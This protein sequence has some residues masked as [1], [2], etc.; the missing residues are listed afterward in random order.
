[1][2]VQRIPRYEL[3]LKE[4]LRLTPENHSELS[5]LE[6]GRSLVARRTPFVATPLTDSD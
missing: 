1:M 5:G 6:Q 2:P 4:I 3:L